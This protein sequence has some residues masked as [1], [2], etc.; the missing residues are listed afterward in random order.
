MS[1]EPPMFFIASHAPE[2]QGGI[3]LTRPL[4]DKSGFAALEQIVS[5]G[6]V[7]FVRAVP[8]YNLL[9]TA[10]ET[11]TDEY[12]LTGRLSAWHIDSESGTVEPINT[13]V[14]RGTT[15]CHVSV[16]A[17]NTC[18]LVSHFRGPG[19]RGSLSVF[20][21]D[22]QNG[23]GAIRDQFHYDGSSVHPTRQR[24]SHIHSSLAA[25]QSDDVYCA[26]LGA[27]RIHH[28]KINTQGKFSYAESFVVE[29]GQGPRHLAIHP[30]GR[31][32]YAITEIGNAVLTFSRD[33][34]SGNLEL[35]ET[36]STLPEGFEDGSAA[37][38]LHVME[39]AG[40]I[41]GS[42]RG[43]DSLVSFRYDDTFGRLTEKN[44]IPCGGKNPR[45][46]CAMG[47]WCL[48]ANQT[49]NCISVFR[50]QSDRILIQQGI[51]NLPMP[52]PVSITF[53]GNERASI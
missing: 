26:D 50:Y 3:Y 4:A 34:G 22:S 40:I 35:I 15:P 29:S 47:E 6:R 9:L 7:L 48:V 11:S 23:I 18:A 24:C 17:D 14:T 21:I 33:I 19:D 10:H 31:Y 2:P 53:A 45:G 36:R 20:P 49:D 28:L 5:L 16:S 8:E 38:D 42:N 32:L 44:I 25:R 30:A 27:D 37:A 51:V 41:I 13:Q 1:I 52:S 39:K 12:A 46:I 43:H